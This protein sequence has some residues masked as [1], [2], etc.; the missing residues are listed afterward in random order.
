V[1]I[2]FVAFALL[3]WSERGGRRTFVW[4]LMGTSLGWLS[5]FCSLRTGFPFGHYVYH[6][7]NFPSELWI[8]GVPLFAS[9]SFAFMSYFAFSAACRLL[10]AEGAAGRTHA[11][12]PGRTVATTFL[13]A[14]IG[15]WMDTVIDPLSLLGEHWFLGDL[16]HYDPPG[17][18]FG[19]PLVN[20]AGWMITIGS[21]V[22]ANQLLDRWQLR[23]GMVFRRG[24]A[25]PLQTLWGPACCIGVFVFMLS[26]N[27]HLLLNSATPPAVP[28][29]RI[30]VS[31][32]T[33]F[34][35]FVAF[36]G[37]MLRRSS[38]RTSLVAPATRVRLS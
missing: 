7:G 21:I 15:T 24:P 3:S 37:I 34:G 12:S 1:V 11:D 20:Y 6:Q 10:A 29:G 36:V 31:G 28:L 30:L 13:A 17:P 33:S 27:L 16:Y 38:D 32:L 35:L 22:A 18:H 5:E 26:I 9:L 25:L 19:V 8:G 2:F 14:I 23:R 4:L